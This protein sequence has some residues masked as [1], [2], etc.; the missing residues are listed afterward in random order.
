MYKRQIRPYPVVCVVARGVWRCP[1]AARNVASAMALG[2]AADAGLSVVATLGACAV[3][4]IARGFAGGRRARGRSAASDWW[5]G[6]R[7]R[8][9]AA[10]SYTHLDVYKR[11]M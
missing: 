10:V 7:H 9:V 5:R 1:D 11:Q 6:A 3:A 8:S 4:A 2:L